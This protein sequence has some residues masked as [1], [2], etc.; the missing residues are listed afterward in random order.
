M[1]RFP[2]LHPGWLPTRDTLQK[3]SHILGAIRRQLT[4]AQP[5][6][7]HVSLKPIPRGLTTGPIE[8]ADGGRLELIQDLSDHA[9][10]VTRDRAELAVLSLGDGLSSRALGQAVLEACRAAGAE[11]PDDFNPRADA[12]PRSFDPKAAELYLGALL[13][14]HSV[15]ES[16]HDDLEGE[17]GPIQLWPHH[18]DLSFEWFGDRRIQ[19]EEGESP[20]QISFDFST[21]DESHPN[22]YYSVSPWPFEDSFADA[23]LPEG[24]S[25]YRDRWQGALLPY[26]SVQAAGAGLLA[27]FLRAVFDASWRSLSEGS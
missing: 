8:L 3:Y 7:W 13:A 22:A 24:A 12:D 10:H 18:F 15:F 23:S 14:T 20:S 25:W 21:G 17:L 1:S 11:L 27:S 19:G 26:A 16:L 5:H 2:E 4:P 6:W 9:L